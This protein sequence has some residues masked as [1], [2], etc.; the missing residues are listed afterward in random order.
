MTLQEG[1]KVASGTIEALK[2]QPLALALIVINVLFLASAI[3][4]FRE[5]ASTSNIER[6]E[7]S[8]LTT[9]LLNNC[10]DR[11]YAQVGELRKD[12]ETIIAGSRQ[13]IV[14]ETNRQTKELRDLL[15]QK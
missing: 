11:I 9:Q 13:A 7:R 14:E 3:Y 1:A 4:L 12:I 6:L 2:S 15:K 5:V 10:G 8:K